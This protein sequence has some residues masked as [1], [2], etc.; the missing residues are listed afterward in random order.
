MAKKFNI[1][2]WQAKQ[3]QKDLNLNEGVLG[4]KIAMLLP[5]SYGIEDFA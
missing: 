3:K 5:D 1:H 4:P 2:E